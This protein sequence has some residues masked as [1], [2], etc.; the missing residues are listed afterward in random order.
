[1]LKAIREAP[2]GG[3]TQQR[4][5]GAMTNLTFAIG[6]LMCSGVRVPSATLRP[7]IAEY[8]G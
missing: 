3:E 6:Q 2:H 4:R 5:D 8:K 7:A 1:M